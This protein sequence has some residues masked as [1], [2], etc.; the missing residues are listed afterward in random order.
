LSG[1]TDLTFE[2]VFAGDDLPVGKGHL[3]A[4][5]PAKASSLE[6]RNRA[7]RRTGEPV[8]YG[9]ITSQYNGNIDCFIQ[10]FSS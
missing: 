5:R 9:L 6:I 8:G 4:G 10:A 3:D 7:A 1:G 2:S